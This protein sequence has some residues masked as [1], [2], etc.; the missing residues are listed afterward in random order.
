M[1]IF[2]DTNIIVDYLA[3]RKDFFEDAALIMEMI[4]QNIVQASIYSLTINFMDAK[5]FLKSCGYKG[6]LRLPDTASLRRWECK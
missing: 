3:C 1:K 2:L 5:N 4:R 6:P